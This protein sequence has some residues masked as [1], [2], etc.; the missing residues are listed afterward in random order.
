[1]FGSTPKP[2]LLETKPRPDARP[3]GDW[4]PLVEKALQSVN[5]QEIK[6]LWEGDYSCYP[7]Q[8]EADLALCSKLAFWL[9]GDAGAIDAAF[10]E[11]GLFREKWD[12]KHHGDG[13][14]YGE[15]TIQMAV[16]G[17]TSFYGDRQENHLDSTIQRLAALSPLQYDQVRKTEA[18]A[19]GVRP[20]TLDAAVKESPQGER[21]RQFAIC[22]N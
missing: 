20:A 16:A 7:S 21:Q 1:M 5:G 12:D 2:I 13:R 22:P 8:S 18:K 3:L 11:S 10:R 14:T 6:R 15:A 19:L 9:A 17:C 4:K